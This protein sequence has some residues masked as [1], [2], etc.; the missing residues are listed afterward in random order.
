[1]KSAKLE[2]TFT[3][4]LQTN[5]LTVDRLPYVV[6]QL[7]SR[8]RTANSR[9]RSQVKNPSDRQHK[10]ATQVPSCSVY[11]PHSKGSISD[12]EEHSN[13]CTMAPRESCMDRTTDTT[14]LHK[15]LMTSIKSIN[16][17]LQ[18]SRNCSLLKKF[19]SEFC[20]AFNTCL[21]I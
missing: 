20:T 1:M 15:F 19:K 14:L 13:T 17:H 11:V 2:M 12:N 16:V 5:N 3:A 21:K 4:R 6:D 9:L 7:M 8:L 10:H 18:S